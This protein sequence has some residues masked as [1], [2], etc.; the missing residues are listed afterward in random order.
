MPQVTTRLMGDRRKL[1]M[2]DS[3]TYNMICVNQQAAN[4]SAEANKKCP[5]AS[6]IQF[7]QKALNH[8]I[9]ED[10]CYWIYLC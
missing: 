6:K 4:P 10:K 8:S 2:I 5:A 1:D 3:G 7:S 9:L